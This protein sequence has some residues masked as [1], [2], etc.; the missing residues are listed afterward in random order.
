MPN[1]NDAEI[2]SIYVSQ[3]QSAGVQD[4]A[5]NTDGVTPATE[6]DVTLE[7]VAGGA[8]ASAGYTLTVSCTDVTTTASAPGLVP[9]FP[10][11]PATVSA[12]AWTPQGSYFTYS[13][14]V[15]V[16]IPGGAG[17]G[18]VYQYTASLIFANGEVSSIKQSE[19][20]SLS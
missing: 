3:T 7:M 17:G 18:Q 10:P 2:T 4:D 1:I 5:P 16:P 6:F 11:A 15:T 14:N 8:L 9:T 19:L 12:P 20:F 13:N